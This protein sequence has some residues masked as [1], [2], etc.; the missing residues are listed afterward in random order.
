MHV[1]RQKVGVAS[2]AMNLE[3]KGRRPEGRF[4]MCWTDRIN[5]VM[6]EPKFSRDG[7]GRSKR[8]TKSRKAYPELIVD[9]L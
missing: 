9:K 5:A 4:T 6:R 2:V 7:F 1:R 8:R 3:I